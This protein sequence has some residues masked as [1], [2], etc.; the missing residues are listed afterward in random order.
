M[1]KRLF[2]VQVIFNLDDPYQA[3]LCNHVTSQHNRSSYIKRLIQR[4]IDNVPVIHTQS[5]VIN[6]DFDANSFI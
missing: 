2:T 6:N 3:K 1:S 5:P 4:D